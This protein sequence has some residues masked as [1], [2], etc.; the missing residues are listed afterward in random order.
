MEEPE[1]LYGWDHAGTL[2]DPAGGYL[3]IRSALPEQMIHILRST[4]AEIDPLLALEPVQPMN[5][6]TSN[7][8][9]PRRFNTGLIAGFTVGALLLALT[10]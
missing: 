3:T 1:T 9:A 10:D 6:A 7:T 4:V 8:E 5:E 2:T